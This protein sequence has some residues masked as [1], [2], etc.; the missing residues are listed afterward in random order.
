MQKRVIFFFG[1]LFLG[2]CTFQPTVLEFKPFHQTEFT[3]R[4]DQAKVVQDN[5]MQL[6]TQGYVLI[7]YIDLRQN[8]TACYPDSGCRNI[9]DAYLPGADE[10][11]KSGSKV[12]YPREQEL[13]F[14]AAH[15]GG[16]KVS[17]LEEK[18]I[19]EAIS[20][21][22]CSYWYT[23][24]HTYNGNTYVTTQCGSWY[25]VHGTLNAKV[26]RALVWRYEPALAS[27]NDNIAA[28]KTAVTTINA[29]KNASAQSK[30]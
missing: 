29:Q 5:V 11:A 27:S 17:L 13:G 15:V 12:V 8:L 3:P 1:V 21:T 20:K 10:D 18:D 28:L 24:T 25:T 26:K 6:V 14:E 2:G 22:L 30:P 23:T 7:G 9:R 19:Q 4:K 16:D